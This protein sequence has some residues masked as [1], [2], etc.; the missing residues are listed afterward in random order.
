MLA[1]VEVAFNVFPA[2]AQSS[3]LLLAC[4][5]LLLGALLAKPLA[6]GPASLSSPTKLMKLN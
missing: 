5:S 2:T 1:G 4:H 3:A 6:Q